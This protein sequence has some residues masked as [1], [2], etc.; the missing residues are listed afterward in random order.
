VVT[1]AATCLWIINQTMSMSK[2][3]FYQTVAVF[4]RRK[5]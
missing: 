1:S 5:L 3:V 4:I 2:S